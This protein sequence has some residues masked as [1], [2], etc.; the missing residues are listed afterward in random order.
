MFKRTSFAALAIAISTTLPAFSQV[1]DAQTVVAT[2]N[3]QE[4]T[5][6][7]MIVVRRGLPEQ[8]QSL[9]DDVLFQGILDQLVQQTVLSQ[10]AGE[11]DLATR[12]LIENESRAM[13]ASSVIEKIA[14]EPVAEEAIQAAYETRFADLEPGREFNASHILVESVEEAEALIAELTEGA[15][16]AELA[17]EKSMGPSGP[18]GGLL[19]WFGTGMMVKEFEDAVVELE[20][21]N[22]SGPVKTQFGW[23][24]IML[25]DSRMQEAP[26]LDMMRD[27]LT[28]ELQNSNIEKR[29]ADLTS[30]ADIDRMEDSEIDAALLR[31]FDLLNN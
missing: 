17:K 22:T 15:D 19:G 10:N 18:N 28:A 23:H 5:L 7:N 2:V 12:L 24:V 8:Y 30:A 27:E 16:F 31:N 14:A 26:S 29:I 1:P 21:G 3:G 9:P 4:I 6:G 25:N 13:I 20:V 11:P